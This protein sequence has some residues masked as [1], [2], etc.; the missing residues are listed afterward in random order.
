MGNK[1]VSMS[2][3]HELEVGEVNGGSL[4]F[5]EALDY[6]DPCSLS[7]KSQHTGAKGLGYQS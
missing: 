6:A 7:L 2:Q 5:C 4:T 3:T 1:M